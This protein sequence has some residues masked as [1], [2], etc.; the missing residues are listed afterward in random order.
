MIAL[1]LLFVAAFAQNDTDT[2]STTV[3]TSTS[4]AVTNTSHT[5]STFSVQQCIDTP[6]DISITCDKRQ[7]WLTTLLLAIFLGGFGVA[8]CYA[9]FWGCGIA[10]CITCGGCGIWWLVD[11]IL[12]GTLAWTQDAAGCCFNT[13]P[14]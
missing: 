12:V 7:S 6:A 10:Q 4:A 5:A 8:R 9:G 14:K 11:V 1:V 3:V 2:N 13:M